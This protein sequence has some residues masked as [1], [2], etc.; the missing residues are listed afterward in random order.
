[1]RG[2]DDASAIV[3]VR[4]GGIESGRRG[5]GSGRG[6]S[7][8]REVLAMIGRTMEVEDLSYARQ[9]YANPNRLTNKTNGEN[10]E[11]ERK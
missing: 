5:D 3:D 11:M 10:D 2:R 1:M 6:R 4:G 8:V 7:R 9:P